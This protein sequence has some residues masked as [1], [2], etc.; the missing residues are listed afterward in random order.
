MNY[1]YL[2][3][4]F[5]GLFNPTEQ[6]FV[7]AQSTRILYIIKLLISYISLQIM[8]VVKE[9]C[10]DGCSTINVPCSLFQGFCALVLVIQSFEYW[11]VFSKHTRFGLVYDGF[12]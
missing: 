8:D 5:T 10:M 6:Y 9:S 12:D 3:D 4:F 2:S 1:I 7:C 11:T